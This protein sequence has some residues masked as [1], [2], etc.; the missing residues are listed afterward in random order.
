MSNAHSGFELPLLLLLG[1]RELVDE[2]HDELARKGHPD[3]RP[4]HGFVFQAVG[5]EGTTA[6]EL[7]R[8]LGVSKQAAG[9]MIA[10]LERLGYLERDG[11]LADGRRKVVRLT[12]RGIECLA[13]SAEGFELLRARWKQRLGPRRL[14]ALENDLRRVVQADASRLLEVPAWFTRAG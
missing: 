12:A 7:G 14:N 10:G 5:L 2:L 6:V 3:V 9:K 4:M 1:F 11:D 8:R 13:L